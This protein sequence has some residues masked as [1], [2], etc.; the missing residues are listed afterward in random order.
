MQINAI[1]CS[2]F[3]RNCLRFGPGERQKWEIEISVAVG[4]VLID[5][6]TQETSK[7][8][9]RTDGMPWRAEREEIRS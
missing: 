8:E 7:E 3:S 2:K 4:L 5:Q 1:K 6:L 9:A